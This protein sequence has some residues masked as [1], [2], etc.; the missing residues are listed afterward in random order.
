MKQQNQLEVFACYISSKPKSFPSKL[1]L[2][3]KLK[4]STK[5]QNQLK[6]KN[7]TNKRLTFSTEK[8][9]CAEAKLKD[10]KIQSY[11]EMLKQLK[12]SKMRSK[13][14]MGYLKEDA[15]TLGRQKEG[16][17]RKRAS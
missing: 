14:E 17:S 6:I 4:N 5:S 16:D 9:K 10:R 12:E 7:N 1:K 11:T 8:T 3:T 15:A 2:K 13:I